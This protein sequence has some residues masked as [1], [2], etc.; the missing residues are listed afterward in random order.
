MVKRWFRLV[1]KK[2]VLIN[3]INLGVKFN[4]VF[5]FMLIRTFLTVV[6]KITIQHYIHKNN[7]MVDYIVNIDSSNV[8]LFFYILL[9]SSILNY[10]QLITLTCIDNLNLSKFK[11]SK[12]FS[13]IYVLNQFNTTSRLLVIVNFS[14]KQLISSISSIYK[15]ANWLE[16][17]V[18][19]LFGVFFQNHSDLRRILTDYGFQGFPLRKD[20]PL[21]GYFEIR[22]NEDK[23]YVK[24]QKLILMQEFR[25]F[26]LESPWKQYSVINSNEK[27]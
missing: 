14:E 16:R 27:I 10:N 25:M 26:N 2:M 3:K 21:T 1:K 23:K 11:K 6:E 8:F 12:R 9:N 24:Y 7:S 18:Y 4:Y 22:Y 5:V 15:A 17:E 13:L 20:F 19:D